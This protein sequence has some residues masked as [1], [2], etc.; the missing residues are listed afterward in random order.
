MKRALVWIVQSCM[1]LLPVVVF[2]AG[3]WL[4]LTYLPGYS[5][6]LIVIWLVVIICGWFNYNRHF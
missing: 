4:F 3:T 6:A 2:I 1:N 5:L